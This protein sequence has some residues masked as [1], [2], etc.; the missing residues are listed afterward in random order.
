MRRYG[1][2]Y[3]EAG[4]EKKEGGLPDNYAV[5]VL[6]PFIDQLIQQVNRLLQFFLASGGPD[7]INQI[8]MAGGCASIPGIDD[9]I[10]SRLEIPTVIANPFRTMGISNRVNQQRL[11][12]DAPAMIIAC[13]LALRGHD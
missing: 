10:E 7:T 8:V 4:R 6:N 1:L 3:A 11:A 2:S 12:N 9:I 13:G 5:E